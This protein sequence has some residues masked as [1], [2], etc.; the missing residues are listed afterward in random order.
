MFQYFDTIPFSWRFW[1]PISCTLL[2]ICSLRIT[3]K[4]QRQKYVCLLLHV[5]KKFLYIYI[6]IY[7]YIIYIYICITGRD[8]HFVKVQVK[9]HYN[10]KTQFLWREY[11][12]HSI[13]VLYTW[14]AKHRGW[15]RDSWRPKWRRQLSSAPMFRPRNVIL[16]KI[17][18]TAHGSEACK[19]VK[20]Y[21]HLLLVVVS[22]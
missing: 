11:F 22:R 21:M 8:T 12:I 7:I 5:G 10:N 14:Q 1:Y 19:G 3:D 15:R 20:T 9:L 16:Y 13:I 6:Y 18:V 4:V 17:N 2:Q